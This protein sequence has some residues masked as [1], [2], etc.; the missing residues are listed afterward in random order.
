[1]SSAINNF[2]AAIV[3]RLLYWKEH[4]VDFVLEAIG[5]KPSSQQVELLEA[6]PH[7]KRIT[8]RSGHGTG[9][10]AAAAWLILWFELTN[11]YPKLSVPLLRRASYKTSSG[12][13][14]PSGSG[15]ASF[16]TSS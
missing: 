6:A 10:D 16:I 11:A 15:R 7:S 14:F 4:P 12:A 2:D 8:I 13:R 5:A 3:D 9:K 1:M